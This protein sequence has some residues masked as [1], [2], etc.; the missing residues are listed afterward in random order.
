M[1]DIILLEMASKARVG[2]GVGSR[3]GDEGID[4]YLHQYKGEVEG[5][6]GG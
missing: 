6:D 1:E 2:A 3:R 5:V 4:I